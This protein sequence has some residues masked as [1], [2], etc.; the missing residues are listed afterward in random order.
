MKRIKIMLTAVCV[1][2]LVGGTF[3]FKVKTFGSK[4]YCTKSNTGD[5]ICTSFLKNGTFLQG[6]CILIKYTLTVN[7]VNCDI[8]NVECP[9]V[10]CIGA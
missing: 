10:G 5:N 6:G 2:A 4:S 8:G 7:T 1:F 9:H 3:A